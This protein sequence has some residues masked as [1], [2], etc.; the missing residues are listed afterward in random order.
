MGEARVLRTHTSVVILE[1]D[2]KVKLGRTES[3]DGARAG[4][5]EA[6]RS[7]KGRSHCCECCR[8]WRDLQARRRRSE[9]GAGEAARFL[10]VAAPDA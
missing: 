6:V 3:G 7:M 10:V 2:P 5:K 8:G 9:Q 4:L 1:A